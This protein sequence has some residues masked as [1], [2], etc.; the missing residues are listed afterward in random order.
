M[1]N[2]DFMFFISMAIIIINGHNTVKTLP[3]NVL[4]ELER[5]FTCKNIRCRAS[6]KW[7]M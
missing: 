6:F 3:F 1:I 2:I 7:K 5:Y 4:L